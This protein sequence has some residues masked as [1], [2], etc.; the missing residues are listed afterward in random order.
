MPEPMS[1][2][3]SNDPGNRMSG[4]VTGSAG[5]GRTGRIEIKAPTAT[6]DTADSGLAVSVASHCGG[7]SNIAQEGAVSS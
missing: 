5:T 4:V 2:A 6:L 3:G 7:T 1:I